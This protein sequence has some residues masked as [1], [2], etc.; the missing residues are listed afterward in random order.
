M[1][2]K[3]FDN[4]VQMKENR[5][6]ADIEADLW[7]RNISHNPNRQ[8]RDYLDVSNEDFSMNKSLSIDGSEI[9]PSSKFIFMFIINRL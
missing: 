7:K 4:I 9:T 1:Q 6:L 2:E 5:T 3:N 8:K